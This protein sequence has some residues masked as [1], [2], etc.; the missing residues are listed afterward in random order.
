MTQST[1]S[2]T[3]A[4]DSSKPSI[5]FPFCGVFSE[6]IIKIVGFG[7][8]KR[9][10]KKKVFWYIERDGE[11]RT[12]QRALSKDYLPKG[13]AREIP[14]A[15]VVD[16]YFPEPGLYMD[17]VAP[18]LREVERL[19]DLGDGHRAREEFYSA[20]YAYRNALTIDVDHIRANFGLGLTYLQLGDKVRARHTFKKIVSMSSSFEEQ[21]KHLFNEFGICLRKNEMFKECLEYYTRA[22]EMHAQDDDHLLFN[23][24]R[25]HF[26]SENYRQAVAFSLKAL[27]RNP[28]LRQ[29]RQLRDASYA[30]DPALRTKSPASIPLDNSDVMNV[31][32]N[33]A[34]D[35]P[36]EA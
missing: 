11:G 20:E 26:Q 19:T 6:V 34:Q 33:G 9:K 7:A 16:N 21:H 1:Q 2:P 32:Q 8:T 28:A 3:A 29:A 25:A 13:E 17:K 12:T 23:I 30:K 4:T 15:D 10:E 14:I 5:P 18:K 36:G 24:A 22:L 35:M 27:E 31:A